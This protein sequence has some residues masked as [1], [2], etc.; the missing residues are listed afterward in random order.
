[1]D[2][3]LHRVLLLTVNRQGYKMPC[4]VEQLREPRVVRVAVIQNSVVAPTTAPLLEQY[5]AI[6]NRVLPW[7]LAGW[8]SKSVH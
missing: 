3:V 2:S 7:C 6:E 4:P 1:M 5:E 8:P